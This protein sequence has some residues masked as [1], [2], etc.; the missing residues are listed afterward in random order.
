MSDQFQDDSV[1]PRP[2]GVCRTFCCIPPTIGLLGIACFATGALVPLGVV[3][4]LLALLL[5]PIAWILSR[6]DSRY[7]RTHH[8]DITNT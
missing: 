3:L 1:Q 8:Y 7:D 2:H 5:V 6:F 4:L